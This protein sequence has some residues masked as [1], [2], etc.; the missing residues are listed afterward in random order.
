MGRLAVA[1]TARDA[2]AFLAAHLGG[3]IAVIWL[4]MLLITVAQFF[5]F[6]RCYN[7]FIDALA[8]GNGA[9]LGPALMMLMGYVVAKLLLFA[10]MLAGTVQLAQGARPAGG[11]VYFSFGPTEWRLFRAF[12]GLAGLLFLTAM[13]VMFAAN[14]ILM[15]PGWKG[16]QGAAGGLML[17]GLAVAAAGMAAR[18]LILAPAIAV[19]ET[20]PVLRRAWSLSAGH[21]W[22]LAGVLL[23]LFLP[24]AVAFLS[25]ELGLSQKAAPATGATPQLQMIAAVMNARQLLPLTCGLSFLLSPLLIGLLTGASVSAWR[26]LKGEPALDVT[27]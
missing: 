7:D 12:C 5:T 15:V 20:V 16:A 3:I 13:A 27:V 1:A 25:L 18:F 21:F 14:M 10:V 11:L 19:N 2:Y 23:I 17:L 26:S 6:W 24:L 22:R 8:S 4:S 9:G